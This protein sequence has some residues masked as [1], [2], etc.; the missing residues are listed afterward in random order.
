MTCA[1]LEQ[2]LAHATAALQDTEQRHQ[3]ALAAAGEQLAERQTQYEIAMARATA[4]W[5]M[6][7]EQLRVAALE[8]GRARQDQASAAADVDRL[9]REALELTSQLAE[10]A[11]TNRALEGRLA[12]AR[13]A[14]DAANAR[15]EHE[16]LAA[17]DQSEERRRQFEAL[18]AQEGERRRSVEDVLAQTVSARDDAERRHASATSDV[19]R[20]TKSETDLSSRLADVTASRNDLERRLAA[21]KAAFD[22]ASMRTT[23]ERLAASKRAAEREAGLDGQ[24]RQQR[25]RC[26]TLEQA[27]TDADAALRD[28]EQRH[29]AALSAAAGDLAERQARFDRE[30]SQT[31]ADRDHV[32]QRLRDAEL[33]LDRLTQRE[34]DLT[35]RLT[36]VEAAR[37]G[38]DLQL[39]EATNAITDADAALRDAE[40]RH[41]AALSAAASDLAERQ[42][43][44]DRE[45]SQTVGDRD[46]LS[47]RLRAAELALDNARHDHQAAA[48]DVERLTQF[49]ADLTS[50]L[51]DVQAARDAVERQL[52]D[53]ASA[54]KH[55]SAHETELEGQIKQERAT[56]TTLEQAIADA[57]AAL[58]Q[59]RRDQQSTA[60]DV[61]RLTQREAALTSQLADV[62]AARDTLDL[63]LAEATNAIADADAALR[64]AELRHKAALS[65]AASDL[66]KRQARFDRELSQTVADRDHVS[67][68]LS[69]AEIALDNVRHDHQTAA[70]HVERL[71]QREAALTFQ[72]GGVEAARDTLEHRLADAVNAMAD[73]D[74]RAARE[75]SAAVDCQADLGARLAHETATRTAVE[76]T[77]NETRAAALDA[78]RSFEEQAS[79][80]RAR[81]LDKEAQFEVFLAQEQLEHQSRLAEMQGCNRTLAL[82]RDALQQSLTTVQEQSQQLQETLAATVKALEVATRRNE[83]L[84]SEADQLPRLHEQLDEIRVDNNRLFEQAGLAMFRCTP[85]GALIHANRACTTLVG[86]RTLDQLPGAQFAPAVFEAPDVLSWLIERCSSTRAKES[87]ETTWQRSDGGRLYVR[88]SARR[89]TPHDVIEVTAEDLTRLRVLQARLDQAHRMEA[90]GRFA[91]EVA[92]TCGT[93]LS[94]IH[95]NGQQWLTKAG[96]NVGSRQQ[97]ELLI[98]DVRRAADLLHQLAAF[99]DEQARTPVLVD[100]NTLIRDL[101]PVLKRVAGNHIEIQLRDPSSPLTVDVQTERVER[102]LVNL[103]SY[104]RER[105]PSGGRLRI[106]LGTIVVNRHFAAKHPQVRLGLHALITVTGIR[107]AARDEGGQQAHAHVSPR[108]HGRSARFGV[109]VGTLHGLVSECGGH[110]WMTVQPAGDMVAKIRLPLLSPHDQVFTRVAAFRGARERSTTR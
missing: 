37:D 99:G 70:A 82:E 14:V 106:D 76:Q 60:A 23:R 79:A 86:R 10:A 94:D 5:E 44:F 59:I 52:A 78:Q 28:A 64:D 4:T 51:A 49:E 11:A 48:A 101:Q 16:R 107:T 62:Q 3:A 40:Q 89:L 46:H 21:T 6:V 71:T 108:G 75:H 103:A 50:R 36:A 45:L 30:L 38:L 29:E 35:S 69:A 55:S 25:E 104:G 39:A 53:T 13:T 100:L 15:T 97:G 98:D 65:A 81:G 41:E 93:L 27:V 31:V 47:Q 12:E 43:R 83:V 17:A 68:R 1:D 42:A 57:D 2:K 73:M 90:V 63:Q 19:E 9:S 88:L 7:D 72:L 91:S 56:R 67:Q 61:E 18:I 92:V 96:C 26:T 24:I 66:A 33:S 8:V 22:D 105:M 109:D 54:L 74:E 77:L 110:L 20:L 32:S 80:L 85:D 84:R 34:A 87:I 102:L 58:G 95:Q